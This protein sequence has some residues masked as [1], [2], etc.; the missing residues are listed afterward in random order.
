MSDSADSHARM[1]RGVSDLIPW[2][3]MNSDTDRDRPTLTTDRDRNRQRF[4]GG[5]RLAA[6][7]AV[8]AAVFAIA[9]VAGGAI[10]PDGG[11]QSHSEED[12]ME[13]M[14]E[15]DPDAVGGLAIAADGYRLE[16]DRNR[17]EA[18][19]RD[20][21]VFRVL[22]PEGV[23]TE[24]EREHEAPLHLIVVRRDLSGFQHLHPEMN[25]DGVWSTPL[26]LPAGGVY[27]AYADFETGERALTLG[28]DLIARGQFDPVELPAPND[29]ATGDGYEVEMTNDGDGM[30]EFTVS[31]GG[32]PV[33]DLQPYLGARGHLVAIRDGDL[34]YLHV[35]PE[36]SAAGDPTIGFHAELP[37]AGRYRLFLQFR[38]EGAVHT[39]AFTEEMPR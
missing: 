23:V 6:F 18:G 11:G 13:T 3:G 20:E 38:H 25:A 33:T 14:T 16:L 10:D 36:E 34:A 17:F 22:G 8:L 29:V 21:L 32:E 39:V 31:R 27:R 7:A 2:G 9:S 35:H 19:E 12:E 37:T 4:G 26:K 24:F 15:T 30:L 1:T 28:A 5:L